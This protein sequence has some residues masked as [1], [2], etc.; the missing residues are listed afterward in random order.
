MPVKKAEQVTPKWQRTD[1][2]V[3]CAAKFLFR[4]V[5]HGDLYRVIDNAE[6]IRI[7]RLEGTVWIIGGS[8]LDFLADDPANR[9]DRPDAKHPTVSRCMGVL[10]PIGIRPKTL[11]AFPCAASLKLLIVPFGFIGGRDE[12]GRKDVGFEYNLVPF[13]DNE[14]IGG[15][16]NDLD[17]L[18]FQEGEAG[19]E[20]EGGEVQRAVEA[21][22]V[23]GST[24]EKWATGAKRFIVDL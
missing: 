16:A 4:R 5:P 17:G 18:H 11:P 22:G 9:E 7:S 2:R 6:R 1:C 19:V 8:L 10:L 14:S 23:F 20:G 3:V 15:C 24:P 21:V 12:G 13:L